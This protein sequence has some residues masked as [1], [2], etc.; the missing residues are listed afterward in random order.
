LPK[1]F[2]LA[3]CAF[4]AHA[5]LVL[6]DFVF[7]DSAY[8]GNGVHDR[9]LPALRILAFALCTWS[10]LRRYPRPWLIGLMAC[11]A[12]LVHDVVRLSEIF[13]GPPLESAQRLL[14]SALFM[15]LLAWIGASF[16]ASASTLAGKPAA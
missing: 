7:F 6:M 9:L 1:S 12:F 11:S 10:L 16:W 14:T 2:R 8:A 15:S 13:A 4:G 5:L 3:A